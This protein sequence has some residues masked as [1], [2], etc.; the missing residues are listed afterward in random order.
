MTEELPKFNSSNWE[1]CITIEEGE[2]AQCP[3]CKSIIEGTKIGEQLYCK[4]CKSYLWRE[5]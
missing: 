2:K 1:K 5:K 4:E 3:A